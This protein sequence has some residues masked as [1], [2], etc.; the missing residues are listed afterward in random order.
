MALGLLNIWDVAH[1]HINFSPLAEGVLP[2]A[3]T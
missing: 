1:Q 2:L 3:H